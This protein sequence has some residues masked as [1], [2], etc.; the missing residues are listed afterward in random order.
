[1]SCSPTSGYKLKGSSVITEAQV[2]P[3]VNKNSSSLYK[4]KINVYNRYY[5]GLILLKQTS[6]NTSHLTFVTEIG[7]KLFD[8][9]IQNTN[10]KLVYIFEPLN[11]PKVI[12]LLEAD[13]KL[14]LL[15]HLL[16]K[17]AKIYEKKNKFVYKI[18]DDKL[19]YYFISARSG[20]VQEIKVKGT[21]F[22][23]ENV[24]YT[25]DDSLSAKHIKLKHKGFIR[26]KIE[27]NKLNKT[28]N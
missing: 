3:I 18:K 6:A 23:K 12:R 26:L 19:N 17:E 1:M 5:S 9:E 7:M 28:L 24:Q 10:L 2:K 21:L 20:V 11:K 16:T 4:A 14:I 27:L 22:T 25:Y 13:M 15:Q 8:F